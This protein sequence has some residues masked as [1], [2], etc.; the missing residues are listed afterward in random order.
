[1]RVLVLGG[2]AWLGRE[3]ATRA[4]ADGH[5]VTC[6]A[7]GTSGQPAGASRI[8]GDRTSPDAYRPAV[9]ALDLVV[10]VARQPGQVRGAVD[11]LA[12]RVAHSV[13]VSSGNVYADHSAIGA[14]ETAPLLPPLPGDVMADVS[15]YGEVKV[16]CERLVVDTLGPGRSLVARVGLIGG[17]ETCSTARA[18]GRHGSPL[19]Q[20]WTARCSCRTSPTSRWRSSTSATWR[21]GARRRRPAARRD[22]RR[23]RPRLGLAEHLEVARRVAGHTGP[24][25]AAS[26]AWLLEQG[27]EP[28]MGPRSLPLWLPDPGWRGFNAR[29]G[30]RA[31]VAG[32]RTRPL[33]ETLADTLAW[34]RS[35]A[36]DRQRRAGLT[37]DEERSLLVELAASTG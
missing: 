29:A 13:F 18:T 10:D 17:P 35:R 19:R 34:E 4:V 20:P 37:P 28:W 16:A 1:M 23:R 30:S 27:V 32:L 22:V 7:R 12:D 24:V 21:V 36:H 5:A 2:T 14:V 3:V 6:L 11:A 9:G 15:V 26:S 33:E 8:Q 31:R 25:R